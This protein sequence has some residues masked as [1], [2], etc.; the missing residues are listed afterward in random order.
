VAPPGSC[1][2][3]PL[4]CHAKGCTKRLTVGSTH[5]RRWH[6]GLAALGKE[7]VIELTKEQLDE[8]I[9]EMSAVN[10]VRETQGRG[11]ARVSRKHLVGLLFSERELVAHENGHLPSSHSLVRRL[12]AEPGRV[13]SQ[14]CVRETSKE[15]STSEARQKA[16]CTLRGVE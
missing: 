4:L 6:A 5:L 1:R 3:F 12:C 16:L 11:R 9:R 7:T 15:M 14:P 8:M 2:R 13:A 10:E